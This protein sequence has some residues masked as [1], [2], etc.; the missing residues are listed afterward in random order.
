L[1][2]FSEYSVNITGNLLV[3]VTNALPQNL[4]TVRLVPPWEGSGITMKSVV[5]TVPLSATC[6]VPARNRQGLGDNPV[7]I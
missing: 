4:S 5:Q 6:S 1:Q 7:C 2:T 3:V